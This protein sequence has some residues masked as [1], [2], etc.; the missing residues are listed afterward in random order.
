M[1]EKHE[2]EKKKHR[3]KKAIKERS[4]NGGLNERLD[5][6]VK[7]GKNKRTQWGQKD[8]TTGKHCR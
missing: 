8:P 3:K 4:E 2:K 6:K 1:K 7:K 5:K